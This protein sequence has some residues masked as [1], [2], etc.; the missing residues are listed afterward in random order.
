MHQAAIIQREAE[1]GFPHIITTFILQFKTLA[2]TKTTLIYL[3]LTFLSETTTNNMLLTCHCTN[4]Q[5]T[6]FCLTFNFLYFME[7]CYSLRYCSTSTQHRHMRVQCRRFTNKIQASAQ[8]FS[9]NFQHLPLIMR[10]KCNSSLLRGEE[11]DRMLGRAAKQ[12]IRKEQHSE[13]LV[14]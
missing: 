13:C 11:H 7:M 2:T 8:T 12:N 4:T 14:P 6:L 10:I 5:T 9:N 1:T 3:I